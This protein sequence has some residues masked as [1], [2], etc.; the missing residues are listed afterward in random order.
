MTNKETLIIDE[1]QDMN[2]D[3][4]KMA[5]ENECESNPVRMLW[6]CARSCGTCGMGN[7]E[8]S[9]VRDENLSICKDFRPN[10][11]RMSKLE[12]REPS[13]RLRCRK[14][15]NTCKH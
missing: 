8:K 6:Q 1:C 3:C 11:P 2:P 15:C 13:I 9:A 5:S 7:A 12:C 14:T 4:A 10:C